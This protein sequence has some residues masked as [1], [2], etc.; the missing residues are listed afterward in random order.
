MIK[1]QTRYRI[2]HQINLQLVVFV[3]IVIFSD[4]KQNYTLSFIY[5]IITFQLDALAKSHPYNPLWA[6]LRFVHFEHKM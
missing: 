5:C 4:Y 1:V 6:Q 3:G 2:F